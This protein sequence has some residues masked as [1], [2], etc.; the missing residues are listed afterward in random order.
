MSCLPPTPVSDLVTKDF[1]RSELAAHG[2]A[3]RA[4]FAAQPRADCVGRFGE[5]NANSRPL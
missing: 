1:L 3:S 2:A 4:E 5:A